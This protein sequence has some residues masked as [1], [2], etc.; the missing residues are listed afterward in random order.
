MHL[1]HLQCTCVILK[2]F[3]LNLWHTDVGRL[4]SNGSPP[5]ILCKIFVDGA[6]IFSRII[7]VVLRTTIPLEHA[8][9]CPPCTFSRSLHFRIALAWISLFL[10]IAQT[11]SRIFST[12]G[13][14]SILMI[15]QRRNGH[16]TLLPLLFQTH[17][18]PAPSWL[19]GSRWY[20]ALHLQLMKMGLSC[21][22][23]SFDPLDELRH[24]LLHFLL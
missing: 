12:L 7:L 20:M 1:D 22:P 24:N 13:T 21:R 5:E 2:T 11:A 18:D 14:S 17:L 3:T 8:F 10:F 23:G 19:R 15:F 4:A 16:W 6:V 9:C